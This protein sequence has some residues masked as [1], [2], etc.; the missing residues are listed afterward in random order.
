MPRTKETGQSSYGGKGK[1]KGKI[2][3]TSEKSVDSTGAVASEPAAGY[4]NFK[5]QKKQ[6]ASVTEDVASA[7]F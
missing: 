2:V 6:P 3:G 7:S 4:K 5:L 1:G